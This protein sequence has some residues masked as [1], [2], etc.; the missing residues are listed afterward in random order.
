MVVNKFLCV[1]ANELVVPVE[2]V[3]AVDDEKAAIMGC[4]KSSYDLIW[5]TNVLLFLSSVIFLT[6]DQKLTAHSPSTHNVTPCFNVAAMPPPLPVLACRP[7]PTT[8]SLLSLSA[9]IA[10]LVGV[11]IAC[12]VEWGGGVG[13]WSE[14]E[15]APRKS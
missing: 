5:N 6:D 3:E 2:S 12:L 9:C 8:L 11:K 14:L 13:Q 10:M 7:M 4:Q 15:L 1:F